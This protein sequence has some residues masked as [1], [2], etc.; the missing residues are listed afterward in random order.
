MLNLLISIYE[1][2]TKDKDLQYKEKKKN[3]T[4]SQNLSFFILTKE[5]AR[6][7]LTDKASYIMGRIRST[8]YKVTHLVAQTMAFISSAVRFAQNFTLE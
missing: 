1:I 4:P 2:S 8:K 5:C 7:A 3:S 6:T